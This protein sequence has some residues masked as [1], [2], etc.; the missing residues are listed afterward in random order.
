M[1]EEEEQGKTRGN[2]SGREKAAKGF[3]GTAKSPRSTGVKLQ[4]GCGGSNPVPGAAL[5]WPIS[6]AEPRAPFA[7]GTPPCR[8]VQEMMIFFFTFISQSGGGGGEGEAD[9]ISR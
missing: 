4:D 7:P 1:G 3:F 9:A 2:A 5:G 8:K 6:H